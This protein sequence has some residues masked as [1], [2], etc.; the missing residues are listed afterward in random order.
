VQAGYVWN[1]S[2]A[3]GAPVKDFAGRILSS[4][5]PGA[6]DALAEIEGNQRLRT[7]KI[8]IDPK[9]HI[10]YGDTGVQLEGPGGKPI[11]GEQMDAARAAVRS[12]SVRRS[13]SYVQR[14]DVP[15]QTMLR[16]SVRG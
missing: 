4:F 15:L 6:D 12:G 16:G 2:T 8:F 5:M 10:P 14:G 7:L 1:P 9:T 13:Q 11:T 3:G